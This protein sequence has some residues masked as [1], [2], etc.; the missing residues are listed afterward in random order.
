MNYY[1]EHASPNIAKAFLDEFRHGQALLTEFPE[2]GAPVL[3][4]QR[5]IQFRRFHYSLIYHLAHDGITIRALA[6]HCHK[7]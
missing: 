6:H 2:I 1:R 3:G 5:V 4:N 7:A